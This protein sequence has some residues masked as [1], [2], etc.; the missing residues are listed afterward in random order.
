MNADH[1]VEHVADP[2]VVAILEEDNLCGW[3]EYCD[4]LELELDDVHGYLICGEFNGT[5]QRLIALW[6]HC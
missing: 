6:N 2:R 3:N 1:V 5:I 4:E